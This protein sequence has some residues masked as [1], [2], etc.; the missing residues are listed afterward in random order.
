MKFKYLLLIIVL[1]S[2]SLFAETEKVKIGVI[3]PL[4]GQF[5]SFS[6][7][8]KKGIQQAQDPNFDFVYEDSACLPSKAVTAYRKLTS[9]DHIKFFIGPACGSPQLAVAPLLKRNDQLAM[10]GSSAPAEVFQSSGQRMFSSQSAIEQESAFNADKIFQLGVKSVV[11]VYFDNNFSKAHETVFRKLYKGDVLETIAYVDG[12]LSNF[13]SI[14][15]RV[16]KL[17]PDGVYMPDASPVLQGILKEFAQIGLSN[18]KFFGVYSFQSD[19]VLEAAGEYG[20][21]VIYSYPAIGD[22]NAL[23]YFPKTAAILLQN[24]IKSCSASLSTDCVRKALTESNKFS[25]VGTLE[26]PFLLKTIRQG[27]FSTF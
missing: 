17:N 10:L 21:G 19:K 8:W 20:N 26:T 4:S 6:E 15:L 5:S 1:L 3:L 18:K 2:T 11:I 13:K 7:D 9:I 27:S 23:T 12:N 22:E 16:K 24:A 14:A 25:A